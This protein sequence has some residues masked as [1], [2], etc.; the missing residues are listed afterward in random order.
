MSAVESREVEIGLIDAAAA[1]GYEKEL[2]SKSLIIYKILQYNNGF[3]MALSGDAARLKTD[4]LSFVT[5]NQG[6]IVRFVEQKVG[7]LEVTHALDLFSV[8]CHTK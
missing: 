3:G 5:S 1:L 8:Y 6:N 7:L 2:E 4:I